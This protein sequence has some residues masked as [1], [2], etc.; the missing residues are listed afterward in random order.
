MASQGGS[1]SMELVNYTVGDNKIVQVFVSPQMKWDIV[2][3]ISSTVKYVTLC[4]VHQQ[5]L[6][7]NWV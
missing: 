2:S 7:G 4:S 1:R 3:A 6:L 5:E